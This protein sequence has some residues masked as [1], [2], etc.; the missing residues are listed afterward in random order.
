[1]KIYL[2]AIEEHSINSTIK[3]LLSFYDLTINTIPFRKKTFEAI[4]EIKCKSKNKN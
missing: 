3:I 1:M 2:A 4:K